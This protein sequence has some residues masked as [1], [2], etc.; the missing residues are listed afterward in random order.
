VRHR[1]RNGGRCQRPRQALTALMTRL[2]CDHSAGDHHL[3]PK[4]VRHGRGCAH[5]GPRAA[6]PHIRALPLSNSGCGV[7]SAVLSLT[8]QYAAAANCLP[9]P[10]AR[11]WGLGLRKCAPPGGRRLCAP[12][13]TS[14]E[15]AGGARW[16]HPALPHDSG[17]QFHRRSWSN[18]SLIDARFFPEFARDLE[19]VDAG[20]LPHARSSLARCSSR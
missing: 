16:G 2:I 10:K 8:N 11:V 20:R 17:P 4:K 6:R 15:G 18:L 9:K 13:C 12:K 5:D 19:R 1:R 14:A 7:R 3:Q